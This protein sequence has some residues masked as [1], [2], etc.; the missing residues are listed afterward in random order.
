[1]SVERAGPSRIRRH[2][3]LE[4]QSLASHRN[5]SI[6]SRCT[7][8]VG[9]MAGQ[10]L[11]R[12]RE[13][14]CATLD[15]LLDAA[16]GG[17]SRALVLRGEPGVG[18]TALMDYAISS[19]PDL[20]VLRAVGVE[21][22]MELAF[23][24]LQQLCL[25]MLDRLERL[26]DPQADALGVAFGLRGGQA[27]NRLL[28]ALATLT[29]LSE[30]AEERP[31][32]C[33]VDDAQ[34]LDG[35]S[36]LAL[37]FVAR[38]L[39][40]EPL[41]ILFVTRDPIEALRGLPE[42]VLD[43][44]GDDDARL[45][46]ASA[47][48]GLLD[49]RIHET[50]IAEARGNPL[51]LLE[52]PR[53]FTPA[54][55][56]GG[57]AL[58]EARPLAD[59]I[60]QSFLRRAQSLPPPSQRLLLTAAA[61]PLGDV[62][63]LWRAAERLGVGP[64]AVGPGEAAGLIEV[65][66]RVRFRHPLVRS[67]TYRAATPQDRREVH[68]ALAEAT[69]SDADPD[70]RAWHRAHAA[71][72][73]DEAVAGDLERSADRAHSRG[74]VAAKAAFLE[75][76]AELTPDSAR[77][78][79]RALAAAQAKLEAGASEAA[80]ALLA[81]AE[82]TPLDDLQRARLLRLHAQIVFALRRGSDAPP[83][84][85]D[86]AKRLVSLD[87]ELARETCLEALAAAIFAAG[88]GVNRT[89]VL[90]VVRAAPPASQPATAIDLLLNGI[91]TLVTQGYAAAVPPLREALEAFR[92]DNGESPATNRWVWLACRVAADLWEHEI[93]DELAARAVRRARETG[94]LNVLPMAASY[95]AGAH[96]HAGEYAEASALLEEASAITEA[97]H[98]ALLVQAK[99]MVAAYFGKEA[100]ALELIEAG[101]RDA[102]ARGQGYA[103]SLIECAN[104]LL[105][106][107]LGRYEEALAAAQR[108]CAQDEL[109]LYALAL[110]ELVEAAVRS[111]RPQLADTALER[112]G[113]RTRASGTEWALGI[114][115]RSRALLTDGPSA[116]PLYVDAVERLARGRLAPHRARAQLVY[117]EWLRRE[118]RRA[119][120][121]K[122]LR[123][124]HDTL[125]GI[126]A[127]AFAERARRELLATGETVRRR[128]DDARGSLTPQEAQI[129]RLARDGLSNPEIGAQLFLSPRT[130]QY[131]LH[132]VFLKLG[133]TSRNQL[134][135]FP[136][137]RL[138][139][140]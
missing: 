26:P 42:L 65:G 115:A 84:L 125:S 44:V 4:R 58:A 137:A 3:G 52:L 63:L 62:A 43:G 46:L 32:L 74:G 95:R 122:Q 69:D 66:A 70:R 48:P 102:T 30:A 126:G 103:L 79:A 67:A 112:L 25:P 7:I 27:P 41:A 34:W 139:P 104:A 11:L 20:R 127:E 123:A 36:A 22:E 76:A 113:E 47:I 81:T 55:L 57:F 78:G 135:R 61:E 140:A 9:P 72:G 120:A 59:R 35:A 100:E 87:P 109:S 117:G 60:E 16:R 40:A 129:A 28:V 37:A 92:Q 71:G 82:L 18:K 98:T 80:R 2:A 5:R 13:P 8:S 56:A 97:T 50:I 128:T 1:M 91:A 53:G 101:R 131:H 23:A 83:L 14:E 39:L 116:E 49:E 114:E 94:A 107:G 45:L 38:R 17:E 75:R 108:A 89:D 90:H 77:R 130:V 133:I 132:K 24:S 21:S 124:A 118:N 10:H 134:G 33:A 106:N 93:W 64:D 31:L 105:S 12:G 136:S 86:A 29:L 119:D 138:S 88:G 15:R 51:A 6:G 85:L 54:E 99:P 121:R 73:L 68:H 110:I 19:V 96:V 111:G